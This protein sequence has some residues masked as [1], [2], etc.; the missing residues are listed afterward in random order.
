[1]SIALLIRMPSSNDND[2]VVVD[3]I[4]C[5]FMYCT[6]ATSICRHGRLR[7]LQ[8]LR[9]EHNFAIPRRLITIINK[10]RLYRI[11]D[12]E[13]KK[14][15]R[16]RVR[17]VLLPLS[18]SAELFIIN[19]VSMLT[20]HTQNGATRS[21][22]KRTGHKKWAPWGSSKRS[23]SPC[24]PLFLCTAVHFGIYT[25]YNVYVQYRHFIFDS[26]GFANVPWII[27]GAG[28]IT[29]GP[30][31]SILYVAVDYPCVSRYFEINI[32]STSMIG[33]DAQRYI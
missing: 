17:Q 28:E 9:K 24:F 20:P 3:T 13:K 12:R 18:V 27:D 1:M 16:E 29:G 23:S 6:L 15:R 2:D 4:R 7:R 25:G 10:Y 8:V 19:N 11:G 32:I 22:R 26:V 5:H 21:K 31:A 33:N 30:C 14:K